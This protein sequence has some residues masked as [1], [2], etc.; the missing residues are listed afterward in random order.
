MDVSL[1]IKQH[2]SDK[3]IPIQN[4]LKLVYNVAKFAESNT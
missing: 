3:L 2:V 1:T 4:S